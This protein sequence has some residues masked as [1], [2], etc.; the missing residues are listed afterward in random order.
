MCSVKAAVGCGNRRGKRKFDGGKDRKGI[1]QMK[2]NGFFKVRIL[3]LA[4]MFAMAVIACDTGTN[5]GGGAGA[6]LDKALVAKWYIYPTQVDNP[7]AEP[8]FEISSRGKLTGSSVSE[9]SEILVTTSGN[10][11]SATVTVNGETAEGG[12]ATYSV[13]GTRLLLTNPMQNGASGGLFLPFITAIQLAQSTGASLGADGCFHKSGTGGT[14]ET[15]GGGGSSVG[16]SSLSPGTK[17]SAQSGC[18]SKFL[19]LTGQGSDSNC[20]TGCSC[21][22]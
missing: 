20:T 5:G 10:K 8:V 4:L 22:G 2:N 21:N 14:G 11:I 17:C 6:S 1:F 15:G 12:T 16:C 19:C 18:S 3:E 13:T 7:D 9:L